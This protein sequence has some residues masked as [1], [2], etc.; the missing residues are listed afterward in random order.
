MVVFEIDYSVINKKKF[1]NSIKSKYFN[2]KFLMH[3]LQDM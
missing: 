2:S 1:Q 3:F